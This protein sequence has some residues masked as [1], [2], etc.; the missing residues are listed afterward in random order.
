MRPTSKF[1]FLLNYGVGN[2]HVDERLLWS[3]A[4]AHGSEPLAIP[5]EYQRVKT[6]VTPRVVQA[7]VRRHDADAF[8]KMELVLDLVGPSR[9]NSQGFLA[10][11]V[12]SGSRVLIERFL[13]YV[14]SD[15]IPSEDVLCCAAAYDSAVLS[16][17]MERFG[18]KISITSTVVMAAA[19]SIKRTDAWYD[20]TLAELLDKRNDEVVLTSE[21][22]RAISL[23]MEPIGW[24]EVFSKGKHEGLRRQA[25]LALL[26][27]AETGTEVAGLKLL[28]DGDIINKG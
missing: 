8:E 13:E 17:L 26:L 2:V 18:N 11:V 10:S 23:Y 19:R 9:A 7:A 6:Q 27:A 16:F 28:A 12:A 21:L 4:C 20:T 22:L 24:L 25:P 1:Q 14:D 3:A 5:F 15:L